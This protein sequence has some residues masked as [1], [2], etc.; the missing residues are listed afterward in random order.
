VVVEEGPVGGP[1]SGAL[2]PAA[3]PGVL[4]LFPGGPLVGVA[5]AWEP[6]TGTRIDGL[7]PP[8]WATDRGLDPEVLPLDPSVWA[9]L[10][11]WHDPVRLVEALGILPAEPDEG[12]HVA[13][14]PV[15]PALEWL[16]AGVDGL[17]PPIG[18]TTPGFPLDEHPLVVR[19]VGDM[20]RGGTPLDVEALILAAVEQ[21]VAADGWSRPLVPGVF[22]PGPGLLRP[23]GPRWAAPTR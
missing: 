17:A 11:P 12:D 4:R 10:S 6:V 21:E 14:L 20:L 19:L 22:T 23:I 13:L 3:A 1:D 2:G 7:S 8:P 5:G 18:P 15:A 9:P 16:P